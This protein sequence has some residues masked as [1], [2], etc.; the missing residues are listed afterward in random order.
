[1]KEGIIDGLK[2]IGLTE[3]EAKAYAALAGLGEATARDIHEASEVPRTRIYDILRELTDKGFVEFIEGSPTYYRAAEPDRVLDRIRDEFEEAIYLTDLYFSF[4]N[5]IHVDLT[6]QGLLTKLKE[7]V[8]KTGVKGVII[9]PWNYIEHKVPAGYTETQYIS[10]A[11]SLIKEFA[12]MTDTHVF[13][14]A[15][16]KKLQKDN[17]GQYPPATMYDI[18][19]SAHFFNKTDNGISVYRDYTNNTVRVY[20]QKVRFHWQ[21]KIGY[22]DYNYDTFTRKYIQI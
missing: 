9:D 18:S 5:I 8:L 20:T 2:K 19:G 17:S 13:I 4:I 12:V 15:H 10:E 16:P 14:V 7:V 22:T 1:M 6:I 11:L 21:G 3:Y